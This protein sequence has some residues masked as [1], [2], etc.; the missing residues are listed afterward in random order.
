MATKVME[1]SLECMVAKSKPAGQRLR[2][3]L[4]EWLE[5]Q[6]LAGRRQGDRQCVGGKVDGRGR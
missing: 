1:A 5:G 6:L 2:C 4:K 3:A